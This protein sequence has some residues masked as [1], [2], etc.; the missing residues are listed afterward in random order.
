M[1][2]A[3]LLFRKSI[4]HIMLLCLGTIVLGGCGQAHQLGVET[5]PQELLNEKLANP[6]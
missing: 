5:E 4:Y 3:Y 1:Y 6:S 2:T